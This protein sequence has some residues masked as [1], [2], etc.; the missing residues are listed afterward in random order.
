M[1]TSCLA[2]TR[3][4]CN[5]HGDSLVQFYVQHLS[6]VSRKKVLSTCLGL[7]STEVCL[8]VHR[9]PCY[10]QHSTLPWLVCY[11]SH[12]LL[13]QPFKERNRWKVQVPLV[14]QFREVS[15][16]PCDRS[17]CSCVSYPDHPKHPL[18]VFSF[19]YD[20]HCL[21][22]Y[23]AKLGAR[24]FPRDPRPLRRQR[25]LEYLQSDETKTGQ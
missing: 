17:G 22:H 21:V 6:L 16:C 25:R 19:C 11:S 12:C 18:I 10:P 23:S 5:Q 24:Y 2:M 13:H 9:E 15:E 3:K 14:P 8:C 20:D 4:G 1:C 7:C